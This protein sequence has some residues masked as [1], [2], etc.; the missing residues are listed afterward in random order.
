MKLFSTS[1][2]TIL[3]MLIGSSICMADTSKPSQ[4]KNST[5]T[6]PNKTNSSSSAS[7]PSATPKPAASQPQ[8]KP[9]A[10]KSS[11]AQKPSSAT[12]TK[13]AVSTNAANN[14]KPTSKQTYSTKTVTQDATQ[15]KTVVRDSKTGEIVGVVPGKPSEVA[16]QYKNPK[17]MPVS[18]S[19][20]TTRN[21]SGTVT[22][23]ESVSGSK[24]GI[25][26]SASGTLGGSQSVQTGGSE[27]T[28]TV[29]KAAAPRQ[30]T[31]I[32]VKPG[33]GRLKVTSTPDKVA[34]TGDL[35]AGKNAVGAVGVV[36]QSGPAALPIVSQA[37]KS[38][39][40][41][42]YDEQNNTVAKKTGAYDPKT[43]VR[44]QA[45]A[46][47]KPCTNFLGIGC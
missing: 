37:P 28:T 20:T 10:T 47:K 23:N 8:P 31:M 36:S 44:I 27:A 46:A 45:P 1:A 39:R 24:T 30:F 5:S 41:V 11:T 26:P 42:V 25:V 18:S 29:S 7:K 32:E 21:S 16:T 35:K 9:A 40:V 38:S 33:T 4:P 3:S 12:S 6:A 14:A 22:A 15:S 19:T 17:M 13:P 43:N 34:V 2:L